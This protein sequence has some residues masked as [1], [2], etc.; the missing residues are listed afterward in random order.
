MDNLFDIKT[1][2]FLLVGVVN[3][4]VG[5]GVMFVLYNVFKANYW[6][7]T[8]SN[9]IVGSIVSFF[10]NKYFTFNNNEK[11]FM[12]IVKFVLNISLCYFIAYGAAKPVVSYLLVGVRGKVQDNLSMMSGMCFFI[13]LNYFG[14]RIFVFKE[15]G[16]K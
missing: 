12:Q 13:V 8:A 16:E 5:A 6:L 7:A 2:K 9:Y 1:V 14:Q 15:K 3:T 10:L 11:S 4:V